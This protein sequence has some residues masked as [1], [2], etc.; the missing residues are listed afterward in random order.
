MAT[1]PTLL[2]AVSRLRGLFCDAAS[3]D[4][5]EQAGGFGEGTDGDAR[6]TQHG[7]D[8]NKREDDKHVRGAFGVSI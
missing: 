6:S 1:I 8:T 4:S 7:E 5:A 2:V 3:A